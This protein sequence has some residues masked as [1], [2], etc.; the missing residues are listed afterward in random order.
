MR[1]LVTGSRFFPAGWDIHRVQRCLDIFCVIEG[2]PDFVMQG[3]ADGFDHAAKTWADAN[4]IEQ[5]TFWA[6]WH[7]RGR[8]AGGER[9]QRMLDEG[10]PTL[11]LAFPPGVSGTYDMIERAE[12]A[13]IPVIRVPK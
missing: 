10:K 6:E 8:A 13:G 11:V 9:N 1:L 7:K 2:R 4:G 3:G 12:A 5:K